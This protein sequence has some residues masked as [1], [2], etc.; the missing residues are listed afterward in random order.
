M[1]YDRLGQ[2]VLVDD[3]VLYQYKTWNQT[4]ACCAVCAVG[5]VWHYGYGGIILIE[6]LECSLLRP[7]FRISVPFA[8]HKPNPYIEL[9]PYCRAFSTIEEAVFD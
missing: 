6:V 8:F 3:L 2:I 7:F 1:I 9:L 5:K 4:S